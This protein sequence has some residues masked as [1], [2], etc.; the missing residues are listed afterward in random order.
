MTNLCCDVEAS[1][2]APSELNEQEKES[3][4]GDPMEEALALCSGSFPTDRYVS[5]IGGNLGRPSLLIKSWG[6]VLWA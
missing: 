2:L 5:V 4:M 3:S 1:A 6:Q